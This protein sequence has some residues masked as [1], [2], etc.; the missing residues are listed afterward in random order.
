MFYVSKLAIKKCPAVTSR[1]DTF[2]QYIKIDFFSRNFGSM[3]EVYSFLC[4]K[5]HMVLYLVYLDEVWDG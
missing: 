4:V 5:C 2:G 3:V 1:R